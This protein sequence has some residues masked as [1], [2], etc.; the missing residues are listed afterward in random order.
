MNR[1]RAARGGGDSRAQRARFMGGEKG[2]TSAGVLQSKLQFSQ[3]CGRRMLGHPG[4][5]LPLLSVRYVV[6]HRLRRVRLVSDDSDGEWLCPPLVLR[7][8]LAQ[9]AE[10]QP[11]FV[12]PSVAL[13]PG[14]GRKKPWLRK[15]SLRVPSGPAPGYRHR[16]YGTLYDA[17]GAGYIWSSTI[18]AGSGSA[19]YLYFGYGG[20]SPQNY[21]SRGY[22]FQLRC[23]QE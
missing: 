21:V 16:D 4:P 1:A 20:V 13:P 8:Q 2:P 18:P 19:H 7:L 3:A 6:W 15:N 9:S 17:G 5:G 12:R 14:I 22:G 11:P 23:L 10:R